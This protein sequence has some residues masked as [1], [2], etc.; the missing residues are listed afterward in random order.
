[1]GSYDTGGTIVLAVSAATW[2]IR[3]LAMY[4]RRLGELVG[5]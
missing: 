1:M 5:I 3:L 2:P 4:G